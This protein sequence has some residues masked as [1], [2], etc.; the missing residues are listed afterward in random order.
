MQIDRNELAEELMLREYVRKAIKIV[1]NRR[2]EEKRQRLEEELKFRKIIRKLI[3]ETAVDDEEVQE[4]TGMGELRRVLKEILPI[5]EREYRKLTT[6]KEQRMSFRTHIIKG[7]QNILAPERA[8][9][10]KPESPTTTMTE[11]D[12]SV[13]DADGDGFIDV[14]GTREE[15]EVPEAPEEG[16]YEAEDTDDTG[17]NFATRVLKKVENQ[18]LT[19]Y[20]ALGDGG[21]KS[22]YYDFMTTNLKLHMDD[23][24]DEL[25]AD[26]TPEPTTPEYEKEKAA[27]AG[28]NPVPEP[29]E[30]ILEIED[31]DDFFDLGS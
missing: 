5:I 21:D 4:T 26:L 15:E 31:D 11:L 9:D 2:Q 13:T 7:I 23:F 28:E 22:G 30:E 29:E 16:E 25:Q 1:S 3:V 10:R 17:R 6:S 27:Q 24:E 14:R 19:G 12:I 18:V 20:N 8:M